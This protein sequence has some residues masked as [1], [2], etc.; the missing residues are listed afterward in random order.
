MFIVYTKDGEIITERLES[1]INFKGERTVLFPMTL[2]SITVFNLIVDGE[3]NN[4]MQG[5]YVSTSDTAP[6]ISNFN[7]F[8]TDYLITPNIEMSENYFKL[9]NP[10][11]VM[12]DKFL[13]LDMYVVASL[14]YNQYSS[15]EKSFNEY[16]LSGSDIDLLLSSNHNDIFVNKYQTTE[17]VLTFRNQMKYTTN[18]IANEV[19]NMPSLDS[20]G[21]GIDAN[22]VSAGQN[23]IA[24][25]LAVVLTNDNNGNPIYDVNGDG[26]IDIEDLRILGS[27]VDNPEDFD[28]EIKYG[29]WYKRFRIENM[30]EERIVRIMGY[31]KV[32]YF[33]TEKEDMS[34]LKDYLV[35]WQKG[36]LTNDFNIPDDDI[37]RREIEALGFNIVEFDEKLLFMRL[38]VKAIRNIMMEERDYILFNSPDMTDENVARFYLEDLEIDMFVMSKLIERYFSLITNQDDKIEDEKLFREILPRPMGDYYD[39]AYRFN[40][41]W[42]DIRKTPML[43]ESLT[44]VTYWL[45][46]QLPE[47]TAKLNQLNQED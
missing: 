29:V 10:N 47:V 36:Y 34:E 24:P 2:D 27:D 23:N 11:T 45:D 35:L 42:S 13:N 14:I 37:I 26:Y 1:E 19:L 43:Q 38:F 3:Y 9:Y 41:I 44:Y 28:F 21:A 40:L 17:S 7:I 15:D 5:V 20:L 33:L 25:D 4:N 46:E 8:E 31:L 32:I 22:E 16:Q 6:N 39:R 12:E 30:T 18:L